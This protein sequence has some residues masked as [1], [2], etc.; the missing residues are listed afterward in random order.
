MERLAGRAAAL[1]P[2]HPLAVLARHRRLRPAGRDHLRSA[3]STSTC[4]QAIFEPLGMVD[5][6]FLVP[7]DK[8]DRL[9]ALL[10]AELATSSW[11]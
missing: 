10:R 9:A 1:P 2:G 8:V 6:G 3:R 11:S 5:T 4:S 7:D